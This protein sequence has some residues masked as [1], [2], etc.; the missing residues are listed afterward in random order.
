M[1]KGLGHVGRAIAAA[2]DGEPDNA[3]T[4]GELCQLAY[5]SEWAAK[6]SHRIAV[7]RAVKSLA[8][9]RPDLGVASMRMDYERGKE[10]VFYRR[11]RVLSL[12]MKNLKTYAWRP[13]QRTK[14]C[15]RAC[16][17]GPLL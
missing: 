7:L 6:R 1:S 11:Y 4:T 14:N 8:V 13:M 15:A 16:A 10:A 17:W 5:R 2:F 12:A 3:F 9:H